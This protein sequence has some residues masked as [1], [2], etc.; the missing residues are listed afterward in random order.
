MYL[1]MAYVYFV[2]SLVF[3]SL[4]ICLPRGEPDDAEV[5][6]AKY[7]VGH[8]KLKRQCILLYCFL[9]VTLCIEII[10]SKNVTTS[11]DIYIDLCI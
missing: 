7:I 1:Y 3:M 10:F 4:G 9:L 6:E 8:A 11:K 5:C 2:S